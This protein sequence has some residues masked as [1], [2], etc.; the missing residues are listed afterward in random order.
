MGLVC[1]GLCEKGLNCGRH[2]DT[3]PGATDQISVKQGDFCNGIHENYKI[4]NYGGGKVI[5]A[6]NA[7]QDGWLVDC[8]TPPP[9]VG[10][11]PQP[12]PDL[13]KM[14]FN[15][16]E[17][18]SH[19]DTTWTTKGQ[20]GYCA[21]IGYCCMPG[22]GTPPNTCGS[23]GC[24][25]RGGCPVRG[26]GDPTRATCEAELCAQKWKCDGQPYPPYR[27]NP[28]QTDCRGHYRTWCSTPGSTAALE[29]DR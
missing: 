16:A 4:Y 19:L 28:A 6:P 20:P 25:P 1:E 2:V 24:I 23:P 9:P 3:P 26:D 29:G 27:G 15:A 5:W 14:K 7:N 12:H 17:K 22:T 11:C 8:G 18:G 13:D 10:D 21:D